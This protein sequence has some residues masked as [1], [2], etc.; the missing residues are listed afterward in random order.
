MSGLHLPRNAASILERAYNGDAKTSEFD[1]WLI[2]TTEHAPQDAQELYRLAMSAYNDQALNEPESEWESVAF[3]KPANQSR[4]D[5][6]SPSL[7]RVLEHHLHMVERQFPESARGSRD[8]E[9][10]HVYGFIALTQSDW[11]QRGVT[12]V[13]CDKDRGMWKVTQCRGIPIDQ[14]GMELTSVSD[15]DDEFDNVR[16]RYD[17]SGNEGQ[18]NQGGAAPHGQWQFLVFST[19]CSHLE[20]MRCIPDPRGGPDFPLGESTLTFRSSE[21]SSVAA[22]QEDFP[23]AYA[24]TVRHPTVP[25]TGRQ[26]ICKIYPELFVVV[27]GKQNVSIK[28]VKLD[29]DHDVEKSDDELRRIGRESRTVSQRI[30]E[31][32][33]VV[34][35]LERLANE[36]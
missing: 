18:D 4:P 8:D 22:I 33:A 23:V 27:E 24:E 5:L 32:K 12:V 15:N 6:Q 34:S 19:E 28:I 16:E 17:G 9:Q 20:A 30:V 11:E 2:Y 29:W 26:R 7:Q 3:L 1:K 13:H 14:L 31:P 35:T 36:D 25:A 21:L 10:S